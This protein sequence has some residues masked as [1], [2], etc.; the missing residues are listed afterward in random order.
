MQGPQAFSHVSLELSPILED[1]DAVSCRSLCFSSCSIFSSSTFLHENSDLRIIHCS[2]PVIFEKVCAS[3]NINFTPSAILDFM[4]HYTRPQD[5]GESAPE[6]IMSSSQG[7]NG[8]ASGAD[9][10]KFSESVV[11]AFML[12]FP[13][14]EISKSSVFPPQSPFTVPKLVAASTSTSDILDST[15]PS[16]LRVRG[17]TFIFQGP[18]LPVCDHSSLHEMSSVKFSCRACHKQWLACKSWYHAIDGGRRRRLKEPCV[19][20]GESNTSSRAMLGIL[21]L[22]IG[23]PRGLVIDLA[24]SDVRSTLQKNISKTF[25]LERLSVFC[26]GYIK[27]L[28]SLAP[29]CTM[30]R[31]Q[32]EQ[33]RVSWAFHLDEMQPGETFRGF[34]FLVAD[35]W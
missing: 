31:R 15:S 11:P 3:H 16:A 13:T 35:E 19:K 33:R 14:P 21:G 29:L 5:F 24:A 4:P 1:F 27:N 10:M 25:P 7:Y 12:A 34:L 30:I 20:P 17:N 9:D 6:E 32:C 18:A 2:S 22:P 23:S 26:L 28:V 8:L